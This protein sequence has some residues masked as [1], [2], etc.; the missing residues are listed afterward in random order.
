MIFG[1]RIA[2]SLST[3]T[4]M[5]FLTGAILSAGCSYAQSGAQSGGAQQSGAVGAKSGDWRSDAPGTRHRITAADLPKPYATDSVDNGPKL[6]P[7]PEGAL[8]KVPA[9]FRCELFA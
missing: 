6:V 9:G 8:P 5:F 7:R 1:R 3:K 4:T 2:G